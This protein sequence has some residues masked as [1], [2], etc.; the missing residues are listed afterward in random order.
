MIVPNCLKI[1]YRSALVYCILLAFTLLGS[2]VAVSSQLIPEWKSTRLGLP[3]FLDPASNKKSCCGQNKDSATETSNT[4]EYETHQLTATYIRLSENFTTTL[5]LNNKGANPLLARPTMYSKSGARLDLAAINVP[6]ASYI[7]VDMN[8]ILSGA[9][10]EFREGSLRIDYVGAAYQMGAQVRMVN[11]ASGVI[12]AEQLIYTS[13]FSSKRLESVWWLP[14]SNVATRL[15]V[16]NTTNAPVTVTLSVDGTT[17][18]QSSPTQVVLNPFETRVLSIMADLVGVPNGAMDNKGGVSITH[19][20]DPGAVLSRVYVAEQG[21]GY[22]AAVPFVDPANTLSQKW[23]GSGLRLKNLDGTVLTPLVIARNTS[24]QT[25]RIRGKIPYTR[26]NGEMAAVD[27]PQTQIAPN[28]TKA[29][30]LQNL[31]D[32]ANVP[33]SVK[34]AGIELTYDTPTGTVLTQVQSVSPDRNHVFQVPMFD[35]QKTPTSAGGYP[36]KAD[37]DFR[38][39][40]YIKNETS[41]PKKF[42]A[43]MSW[44]GGG[45]SLGV[46]VIKRNQTLAIDFRELR[47]DQTPDVSG[48]VI[49]LNLELGQIA[50]SSATPGEKAL[51]GR[52]EQISEEYGL[53]STYDCRNQCDDVFDDGWIDPVGWLS[54][55]GEISNFG[56]WQQDVNSYGQVLPPYLAGGVNWS[57]NATAVSDINQQGLATAMSPGTATIEASWNAFVRNGEVGGEECAYD[58]IIVIRE[59][60]VDVAPTVTINADQTK[61][62]GETAN[63]SVTVNPPTNVTGY[64]WSFE[65][66]SDAGNS[67]QVNFA[68]PTAA[69]TTA[70]AHWFAKPNRACPTTVGG[71]D[72]PS[73]SS[74]YTIKVRVSFSNRNPITRETSLTVTSPDPGGVVTARLALLGDVERRQDLGGGLWRVVSLGTLRRAFSQQPSI[75]IDVLPDTQFYHKVS[76]HEM[77]HFDDWTKPDGLYS[78]L[79]LPNDFFDRVRNFTATSESRLVQL[80]QQEATLF[81]ADQIALYRNLCNRSEREAYAISDPITPQFLYQG[82]GRTTFSNCN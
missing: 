63:F 81:D 40:L 61:R 53:A 35:P 21:N 74:E 70:P 27:I 39:I 30:N 67:P 41:E 14:S 22:S 73:Y 28:S 31:I 71:S 15:V 9:A 17:P 80:L 60:P 11:T 5:M 66:P 59:S 33:A 12:W 36:W 76:T 45:Y 19:S 24:G 42:K 46:K 68:N 7:D 55:V 54:S 82:C 69:S 20:G 57:S 10:P 25:A 32:A 16:S 72:G 26:P 43:S 3:V 77:E 13:H 58:P 75:R 6:A 49:P 52:S 2:S 1:S 56:A 34:H 37:G 64:Q 79:Y 78:V 29:I 18:R 44:D 47:D 62:D 8:Q 4:V 50:W 65:A 23:H 51:S 38:T 48:N